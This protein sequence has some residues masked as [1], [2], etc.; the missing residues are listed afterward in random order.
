M[1][2]GPEIGEK[3]APELLSSSVSE[4]NR[5]ADHGVVRLCIQERLAEYSYLFCHSC[6]GYVR[7]A[8]PDA[9]QGVDVEGE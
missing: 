6:F 2:G 1:T 5:K 8:P 9:D 4:P 3:P 7:E